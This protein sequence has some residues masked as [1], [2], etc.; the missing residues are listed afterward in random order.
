MSRYPPPPPPPP[1]RYQQVPGGVPAP[2]PGAQKGRPTQQVGVS[3]RRARGG[4]SL[5]KLPPRD[6]PG[7]GMSRLA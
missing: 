2:Q 7:D 4:S 5:E 6:Q 3:V 1:P